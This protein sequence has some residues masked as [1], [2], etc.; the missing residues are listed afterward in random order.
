MSSMTDSAWNRIDLDEPA[1][2]D[3]R[4]LWTGGTATAL[5]A[6]LGVVVGVLFV[7]G[8]LGVSVLAPARAGAWGGASTLAYAVLAAAA[9]FAATGL[10]HVLLTVVPSPL[11]FFG[12]IAGLWVAVA[13]LLPFAWTA[14]FA[15]EVT[16]A[17]INLLVGVAALGLLRTVIR[18]AAR[19][20]RP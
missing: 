9:V 7:R 17:V 20:R 5:V 14:T 10:A 18:A 2:P 16:T 15:S 12:W 6:A 1:R 19:P 8:L 11:T 4:L 3:A 13:A